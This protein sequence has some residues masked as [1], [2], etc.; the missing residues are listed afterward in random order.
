VPRQPGIYR[1]TLSQQTKN[2]T[3]KHKTKKKEKEKV[4]MFLSRGNSSA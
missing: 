2:K 4:S 3:N 1:K